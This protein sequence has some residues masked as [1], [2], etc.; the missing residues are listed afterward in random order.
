MLFSSL[1]Y[2]HK[3]AGMVQVS[4]GIPVTQQ[5]EGADSIDNFTA[6]TQEIAN[7]ICRQSKKID[8]LVES[9]P[10][11]SVT[12]SEQEREFIELSK[13]NDEATRELEEANKRAH[14]LLENISDTLQRIAD[15]S[16]NK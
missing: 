1:H 3:K 9:L 13:E 11:V 2:L 7:D 8:T 10:G 12:E 15:N 6:R 14:A 4:S 16:G 5:N